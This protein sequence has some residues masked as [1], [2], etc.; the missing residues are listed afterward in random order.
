MWGK[1]R[2]C[3]GEEGGSQGAGDTQERVVGSGIVV[4]R[5]T[6][7]TSTTW[8][9]MSWTACGPPAPPPIS[10]QYQNPVQ[11]PTPPVTPLSPTAKRGSG[12]LASAPVPLKRSK[13]AGRGSSRSTGPALGP[14]HPVPLLP[15]LLNCF[16]AGQGE[17]RSLQTWPLRQSSYL[18]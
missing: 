4:P 10:Q 13:A 12:G 17:C 1:R 2:S 9:R 3:R 18:R 7:S 5:A 14:S 16:T 8:N 15:Q 11:A 6:M